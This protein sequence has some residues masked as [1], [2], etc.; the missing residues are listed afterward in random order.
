MPI[1]VG[2]TSLEKADIDA[3]LNRILATL[4][5]AFICHDEGVTVVGDR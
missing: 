1:E 5:H 4:G 2:E 3:G